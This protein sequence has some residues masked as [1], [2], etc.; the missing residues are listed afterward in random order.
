M[1]EVFPDFSLLIQIVNFLFLVF[2][3]NIILF[4][5]VRTIIAERKTKVSA[6]EQ[7]IEGAEQDALDKDAAYQSGI[8]DARLKGLKAKDILVQE[9]K[10][11]ERRIIEEINA[12]AQA[13]LVEVRGKIASEAR[14]VSAS[15]EAELDTFADAIGQKILGRAL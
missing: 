5:P 15:L 7:S 14:S 8:K 1:I 12:K 4:K 13:E 10:D 9:A 2:A 6:L 3:L 11:E